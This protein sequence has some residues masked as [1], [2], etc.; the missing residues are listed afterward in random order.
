M[1]L[2]N[3]G[4]TDEAII[5]LKQAYEHCPEDAKAKTGYAFSLMLENNDSDAISIA[6]ETIKVKGD[7]GSL[8]AIIIYLAS[9]HLGRTLEPS[10]L[11]EDLEQNEQV[12]A[13]RLEY[14][15]CVNKEEFIEELESSI[16]RGNAP[17][18]VQEQWALNVLSDMR[19]NQA[20]LLGRKYPDE[21]EHRVSKAASILSKQLAQALEQN[22]PNPLLLPIQANNA[23]VALRLIGEAEKAS[24][25]IDKCVKRFPEM[26]TAMAYPR[27]ILLLE[28]DREVDAL[29]VINLSENAPTELQIMAA[30]IEA[31]LGHFDHGLERI[32]KVV[33]SGGLGELEEMALIVKCRIATK[34]LDQSSAE[35]AIEDLEVVN[36]A[37]PRLHLLKQRYERAFSVIAEQDNVE[38]E[39]NDDEPSISEDE[40]TT[41]VAEGLRCDGE[42][43]FLSTFEIANVLSARG[44]HQDVVDLLSDRTS[45]T[46]ITP[47]LSLLADS[48]IR[49]GAASTARNLIE[50][51]SSEVRNSAF[52]QKFELSV[53]FMTGEL[54]LC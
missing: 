16:S 48:C 37:H 7:H 33:A 20:Y 51:L 26:A 27:A 36:P 47:A 19:G 50:K 53:R 13:A 42:G 5:R 29:A 49:A 30:E 3:M 8:A 1:V 24:A 12:N 45:L 14:L 4:R 22:P 18:H 32:N 25:L 34:A 17:E 21:F 15:K 6:L 28:Q 38:D 43:D 41:L 11:P 39:S 2:H 52:G 46:R 35:A 23:A 40:V 9:T 54:R 44:C 31:S 10:D